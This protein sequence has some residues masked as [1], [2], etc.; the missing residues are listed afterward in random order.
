MDLMNCWSCKKSVDHSDDN[1]FFWCDDACKA[2]HKEKEEAVRREQ[3]LNHDPEPVPAVCQSFG[4]EI[5]DNAAA[6]K[7]GVVRA[8]GKKTRKKRVEKGPRK[9]GKC[10]GSGHNARTCGGK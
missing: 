9:C 8:N 10:G 1:C 5:E 4:D 3:R 7:R 2:A 6:A